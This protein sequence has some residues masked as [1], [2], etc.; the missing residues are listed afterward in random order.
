ML[1]ARA[2]MRLFEAEQI[3]V[4]RVLAEGLVV[5]VHRLP[6]GKGLAVTALNFGKTAVREAVTIDASTAGAD[7][8]DAIEG[9]PSGKLAGKRLA[10]ALGAHEGQVL[11]LK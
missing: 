10:I 3:D 8:L 4:P 2:E 11:L 6:E 9:K 1:D 7:V 5:M